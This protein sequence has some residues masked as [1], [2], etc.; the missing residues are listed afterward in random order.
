M[1]SYPLTVVQKIKYDS[2]SG[3]ANIGKYVPPFEEVEEGFGFKGVMIEDHESGFLQ[4]HIC[5]KWF[6]IFNSHLKSQHNMTSQEYREKFGLSK[7]T[8]LR[9]K[10]LRLIQSKVMSDLRRNNPQ[11][12]TYKFKKNNYQAS[13]RK[14]KP[15]SL[16]TVNKFGVCDLQIADKIL[17]LRDKLN[18]TPSLIDLKEEYG[19]GFIHH[20]HKRYSSYIKLCRQLGMKPIT[21]SHNP[22]YS[23]E[24]FIEKFLDEEP[25]H[26]LMTVTE[27]RNMYKYFKDGI[28]ELKQAVEKRRNKNVQTINQ[29][30]IKMS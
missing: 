11:K 2:P 24:Y 7:S 29:D 1:P 14:D 25:N 4:C 20:I 5:G 15:K 19:A 6:E 28:K 26:R 10:R 17:K 16:E 13:N 22:K 18:K 12:H 3:Y 9:S 27:S 23:R 30:K 21:S 8:A